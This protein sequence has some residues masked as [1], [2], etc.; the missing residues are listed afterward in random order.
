MYTKQIALQQISRHLIAFR[1][2]NPIP[3]R[4][5]QSTGPEVPPDRGATQTIGLSVSAA[6]AARSG[7]AS[8][9]LIEPRTIQMHICVAVEDPTKGLH[10]C[11]N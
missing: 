3:S 2:R 1:I 5:S 7:E 6:F 11:S 8:Q 4:A 9:A 10:Q